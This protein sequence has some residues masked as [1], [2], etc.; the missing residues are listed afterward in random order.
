[1]QYEFQAPGARNH[2]VLSGTELTDLEGETTELTPE[3][4]I[5]G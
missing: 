2:F 5:N 3:S 4:L 1:M